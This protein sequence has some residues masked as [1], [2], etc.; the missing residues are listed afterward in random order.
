MVRLKIEKTS[1]GRSTIRE[2]GMVLLS[3]EP[4][5]QKDVSLGVFALGNIVGGEQ[6]LED[7]EGT[8]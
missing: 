3:H 6:I 7:L 1:S 4:L 2:S 8:I 5:S